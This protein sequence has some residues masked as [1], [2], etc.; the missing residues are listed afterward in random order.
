MSK[1]P[2]RYQ[3][4]RVDFTAVNCDDLP[5]R[6]NDRKPSTRCVNEH[7]HRH[8]PWKKL[9]EQQYRH[10]PHFDLYTPFERDECGV[11]ITDEQVD[12]MNY[13]LTHYDYS[14]VAELVYA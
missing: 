12:E 7:K 9:R 6:A 2:N 3:V 8:E 4:S 1:Y 10:I 5:C 11:V 13:L 14:A